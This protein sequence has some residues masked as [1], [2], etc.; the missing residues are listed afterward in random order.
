MYH[1][2]IKHIIALNLNIFF[3]I[4][5]PLIIKYGNIFIITIWIILGIV[6]AIYIYRKNARMKKEPRNKK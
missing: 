1:Y 2:D 3:I 5:M 6:N 4:F